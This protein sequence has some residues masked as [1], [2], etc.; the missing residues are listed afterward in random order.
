[1]DVQGDSYKPL[2]FVGGGITTKENKILLLLS[3]GNDSFML[4]TFPYLWELTVYNFQTEVGVGTH[5]GPGIKLQSKQYVS[6][7][8]GTVLYYNKHKMKI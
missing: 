7:F 5:K 8:V 1:M 2:S 6:P 4:G 3:K